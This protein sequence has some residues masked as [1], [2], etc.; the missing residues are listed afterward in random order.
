[1]SDTNNLPASVRRY[2][3]YLLVMAG[4]GGLL[5]GIDVGVINAAL[6]Y[7]ENTST[8]TP[9]QLSVVVAAV[10]FGSVVSSL[11]AGALTEAIG[12]KKVILLSALCFSASIPIICF[13]NNSF[14]MLMGG[15]I[16]Q[17]GSAGLVG[18]VVPMYLAECLDSESRGK[19]TGMFQ[20]MLTIGLVFA[21]TIGLVVTNLV[22]AA[23]SVIVSD[24]TKMIAWQTIFWCSSIPGVILFFGAFKLKE[25]PRW[26]YKRGRKD[27]AIASLA[28][29]N[30]EEKAR[31]ILEEM[32]AADK[33]AEAEK[34]AV[35]AAAKGDSLFQKKYVIPFLLAVVILACN[36][37][38]GINSVLNYSV[39]ILQQAGLS[40]EASTWANLGITLTNC[41]MTMVACALV[42]KKGRKFLLKLGTFGIILGLAGVGALFLSVERNRIDVTD[43]VK[44]LVQDKGWMK[45]SVEDV[46]K[47]AAADR[48]SLVKDGKVV[49]GAQLIV[50]YRQGDDSQQ[51]VSEYFDRASELA[52]LGAAKLEYVDDAMS[53]IDVAAK[54]AAFKADLEK[55]QAVRPK[56]EAKLS[57]KI[58]TGAV[59]VEESQKQALAESAQRLEKNGDR[60]IINAGFANQPTFMDKLCFWRKPLP[61]GELKELE[62]M[63][64]ELG[65]KPTALLGWVV[66]FCFMFFIAF[67]AAGPGVCVWLALSELMPTR[68]RANGMAIAMIINQG[69]S[70]VIA[71]TFLPW[72]G[73]CGYSSV[74]FWLAGFTVIYFI[75]AAFFLPETKGRTLEEIEQY[76]KTGKMPEKK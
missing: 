14:G 69:V 30:G 43:H 50:T 55:A 41:L 36:Q 70:T 34:A 71:G 68:I 5:Y 67:Y 28:A 60:V 17:G 39:K 11:F 47:A 40:G 7:I 4:L 51:V 58:L 73:A 9:S 8:Y 24:T 62:I 1:M 26:L 23:D 45:A 6:P 63:K 19:G 65:L 15:R 76:F 38:T 32:I 42:D 59:P 20:F 44:T 56:G 3:K 22:G 31:E 27:E 21:A 64:A 18:V 35:A 57:E 54:Q 49:D 25:S 72:V 12:R 74:F 48:Q 33:A 61:A 66:T 37:S 29:N 16:L 10:L 46:A 13:S 2:A 75:T 53:A 52:R